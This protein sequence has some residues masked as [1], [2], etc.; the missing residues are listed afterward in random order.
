MRY[1][2]PYM[3]TDPDASYVD[4]STPNAQSGSRVP[5]Y[6]VE[7]PQR[8]IVKVIAEAGLIPSNDD[9]TQLWQA[10]GIMIER[11]R[12]NL[13]V[14][15]DIRTV[16]GKMAVTAVSPGLIRIPAGQQFVMR[17]GKLVETAVTD[18]VTTANRTCHLRWTATGGFVLR[19]LSDVSYNPGGV[20]GDEVLPKFDSDY[21]DMLVARVVTDGANVATIDRLVNR[22]AMVLQTERRDT[23]GYKLAWFSLAGS[24]TI[25]NWSRTPDVVYFAMNEWRSNQS[26]PDNVPTPGS[27]GETIAIGGRIPAVGRTRYSLPAL[28]Y[29]YEDT[30]SNLGL[31]SWTLLI[32]ALAQT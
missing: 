13:Q 24:E 2:A 31:A 27:A 18:L 1:N 21:D 23:L 16:D 30:Q 22:P 10:I 20:I 14:Y 28:E 5:R 15:P 4:R 17:G 3:S 9:V 29:Y 7:A 19:D 11:V 26:G 25:L 32:Q 6:A 8:E 12:I